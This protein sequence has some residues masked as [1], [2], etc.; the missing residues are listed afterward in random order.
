MAQL[1]NKCTDDD[2]EYYIKECGD[3]LGVS[4]QISNPDDPKAILNYIFQEIFKYK[5]SSLSWSAESEQAVDALSNVVF[6]AGKLV[7]LKGGAMGKRSD[8][9]SEV[10]SFNP[11]NSALANSDIE[12]AGMP[13]SDNSYAELKKL[14]WWY[15]YFIIYKYWSF[16]SLGIL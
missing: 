16:S 1:T 15:K 11:A 12:N 5:S 3:I 6:A 4:S 8:A 7:K 9:E 14:H 10:G 13:D 2:V